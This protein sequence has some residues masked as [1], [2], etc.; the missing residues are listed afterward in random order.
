MSILQV[1]SHLESPNH[2]S[3]INFLWQHGHFFLDL[4]LTTNGTGQRPNLG[5]LGWGKRPHGRPSTLDHRYSLFFTSSST[6]LSSQFISVCWCYRHA[7]C[8]LPLESKK[9]CLAQLHHS[10][11]LINLPIIAII[12]LE[13]FLWQNAPTKTGAAQ[14]ARLWLTRRLDS[15]APKMCNNWCKHTAQKTACPRL[16]LTAWWKG[17]S[18][19]LIAHCTFCYYTFD[20]SLTF[21]RATDEH[22][23]L[24]ISWHWLNWQ[25]LWM[26]FFYLTTMQTSGLSHRKHPLHGY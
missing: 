15:N 12:N 22:W 18:R 4:H 6:N 1:L 9:D 7:C 21:R 24:N 16:L 5:T 2:L 13:L 11:K 23:R 20:S 10:W 17:A 26:M 14:M 19:L 3:P 8:C 25:P